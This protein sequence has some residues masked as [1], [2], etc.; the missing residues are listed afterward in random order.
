MLRRLESAGALGRVLDGEG[1]AR[2]ARRALGWAALAGAMFMLCRAGVGSGA[3]GLA[4][5]AMAFFSAALMTGRAT[6][7]LLAG[8]LAGAVNGPIQTWD[9]RLPIGAALVLGG[10]IAWDFARPA[11]ARWLAAEGGRRLPALFTGR[12]VSRTLAPNRLARSP[13]D[14]AVCSALAGAGV[15]LPGLALLGEALTVP[16]ALEVTAASVAAVAAAPFLRAALSGPPLKMNAD[17]RAGW[18]LLLGFGG[19]GLARLSPAAAAWAS[20]TLTFMMYPNGALAGAAF[21]G[22][23]AVAAGD[24]RLLALVAAGGA[25]AQ[26]CARWSKTARTGASCGAMLAA[27][28]YLN[29]SPAMLAGALLPGVTLLPMPEEWARFFL[30]LSRSEDPARREAA[31][32]REASGRVLALAA[33][34][35][36]IAESEMLDYARR[37]MEALAGEL[38]RPLRRGRPRLRVERAAACES[39]AAGEVSGDCH[40]ICGVGGGRL[41]AMIS[42]GMGSGY[43]AARESA[44]AARLVG[45]LLRAGAPLELAL[46]AANALL[47]DRFGEDMFATADAAVIDFVTGEAAFGK[48]AAGPTL[49]LRG[50]EVLRV[51]GGGLPLGIVSGV[52]PGMARIRLCPGDTVVMASDGVFDV[53]GT[54]GVEAR[55]LACE[56]LPPEQVAEALLRA[57]DLAGATDDRTAVCLQIR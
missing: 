18:W 41:L 55:L 42:D 13:N 8:C 27:G 47:L 39:R 35:G 51:P 30:L 26:L 25:T 11:V 3:A 9:V 5:F 50:G 40:L 46:K 31:V 29:L 17:R 4:P 53:L 45:R 16:S 32:R 1:A 24:V 21:G 15:L 36:E 43:P 44:T 57:A 49:I 6:G 2:L 14:G 33:A 48:L 54:E 22:A 38:R 19:M 37:A 12:R 10:S 28:I 7:A 34:L 52:E 23:L 56:G 20:G